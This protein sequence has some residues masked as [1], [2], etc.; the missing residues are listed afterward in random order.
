MKLQ[1]LT[2]LLFYW[3]VAVVDTSRLPIS[4]AHSLNFI[5][6][7]LTN[8]NLCNRMVDQPE[9]W[10]LPCPVYSGVGA[11]IWSNLMV[12]TVAFSALQ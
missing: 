9:Y 2:N 1:N 4:P 11:D 12:A 8:K 7:S 5:P 10:M 6:F 3:M